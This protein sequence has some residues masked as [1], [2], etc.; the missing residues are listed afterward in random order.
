MLQQAENIPVAAED[1]SMLGYAVKSFFAPC[2]GTTGVV[3]LCTGTADEGRDPSNADAGREEY[4]SLSKIRKLFRRITNRMEGIEIEFGNESHDEASE[5]SAISAHTLE[6]LDRLKRQLHNSLS[7]EYDSI[8]A[9]STSG[10]E[11]SDEIFVTEFHRTIHNLNWNLLRFRLKQMKWEKECQSTSNISNEVLTK[12]KKESFHTNGLMVG[13][14]LGRTP[15]HLACEKEAPKLILR[16]L[17]EIQPGAASVAD[18]KG[19]YAI[20]VAAGRPISEK[21]IEAIARAFPRGL[22]AVDRK[23]RSPLSLALDR[24]LEYINLTAISSQKGRWGVAHDEEGNN[25]QKRQ[26]SVWGSIEILLSVMARLDKAIHPREQG[27]M[28]YQAMKTG[29]PP[30]IIAL[31]IKC[32]RK[33]RENEIFQPNIA[34]CAKCVD[35]TF[36][37]AFPL[38]VLRQILKAVSYNPAEP[39][40]RVLF[41]LHRGLRNHFDYGFVKMKSKRSVMI[42]LSE[43]VVVWHQHHRSRLDRKAGDDDSSSET[44]SASQ[45]WFNMLSFLL[46]QTTTD[47]PQALTNQHIL[48]IAL[49]NPTSPLSLIKLIVKVYPHSRKRVDPRSGALPLHIAC[50]TKCSSSENDAAILG[51]VMG[52]HNSHWVWRRFEDRLPLHHALGNGKKHS[53]IAPLVRL[54]PKTLLVRDPFTKLFPFQLAAI[55]SV[56]EKNRV[57]RESMQILHSKESIFEARRYPAMHWHS[58]DSQSRHNSGVDRNEKQDLDKLTT[59]FE[60]VKMNPNAIGVGAMRRSKIHDS[61]ELAD[62]G[63]VAS[64]FIHWFYNYSEQLGWQAST[65]RTTLAQTAIATSA[66]PREMQG[67]WQEALTLMWNECSSGLGLHQREDQ[68]LLHCA[69]S[70]SD[71]PPLAIEILLMTMPQTVSVPLPG[72]TI[73]PVHI[74]ASTPAYL[75]QSFEVPISKTSLELLSEM[76]PRIIL[77][78][79]SMGRSALHIAIDERKTRKELCQLVN[80]EKRLLLATDAETGLFPF[81]MLAMKRDH[82]PDQTLRLI[83]EAKAQSSFVHWSILSS[84]QKSRLIRKRHEKEEHD[85][86]STLFDFIRAEPAVVEMTRAQIP[87]HMLLNDDESSCYELDDQSIE[88][89]GDEKLVEMVLLQCEGEEVPVELDIEYDFEE[90]TGDCGSTGEAFVEMV[91]REAEDGASVNTG[92]HE[93]ECMNGMNDVLLESCE[94]WRDIGILLEQALGQHDR[95]SSQMAKSRMVLE[96]YDARR[97]T[98]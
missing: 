89:T 31:M 5:I 77:I 60:L 44:I 10:S 39:A 15:L 79:S 23:G 76:T 93:S 17:V 12:G 47:R 51:S 61:R 30:S 84:A 3:S 73:Y 65:E 75:P 59:I 40:R 83:S 53:F 2:V 18:K 50:F 36:Q 21:D 13:D 69:V 95:V 64:H 35:I 58:T 42:S 81:Q 1:G 43:E 87:N 37:F 33:N 72:T 52:K 26:K 97:Q 62:A 20:H 16:Q 96:Q 98:S 56:T 63:I 4:F 70:N 38:K 45:D 41:A 8:G 86:L 22:L 88:I 54:D 74:A 9:V 55:D 48:H 25:W 28:I 29:A 46:I 19:Q 91:V 49:S 32:S 66:V 71:V 7:N 27:I 11:L 6:E 94:R 82:T 24:L 85:I 68:F 92:I 80:V 14:H 67:F 90:E 78:D 57:Q 34:L